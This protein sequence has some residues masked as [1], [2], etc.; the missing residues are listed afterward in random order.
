MYMAGSTHN[1]IQH[2]N[3][4]KQLRNALTVPNINPK[5]TVRPASFY[6]LMMTTQ[7]FYHCPTDRPTSA[8]Y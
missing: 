3:F 8:N 6:D 7:F 4:S 1:C 5:I 2:S